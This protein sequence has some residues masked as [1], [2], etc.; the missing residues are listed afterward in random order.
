MIDD[1][2]SILSL[3]RQA[4]KKAGA[5]YFKHNAGDLKFAQ[6]EVLR[7][8]MRDGPLSQVALYP[9]CA[10]DRSTIA[11]TCQALVAKGFVTA[12]R[13]VSDRRSIIMDCTRAGRAELKRADAAAMK[14]DIALARAFRDANL[15]A[16][17]LR[18]YLKIICE[19]PH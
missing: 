1:R 7:I 17:I 13:S 4:Q 2:R 14:V 18:S 9:L 19:I 3:L 8:L 16:T 10:S 5:L 12:T 15:S 6:L 11:I